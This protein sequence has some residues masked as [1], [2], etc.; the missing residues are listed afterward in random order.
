MVDG[1]VLTVGEPSLA[2]AIIAL[3]P[4]SSCTYSLGFFLGPGLPRGLGTPSAV[5][6]AA[7]AER[8][9]PFFLV[10]SGGAMEGAGVPSPAGVAALESDAGSVFGAAGEPFMSDESSGGAVL[11]DWLLT[12]PSASRRRSVEGETLSVTM[13]LEGGAIGRRDSKGPIAQSRVWEEEE[14]F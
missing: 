7:A 12:S 6:L 10:L 1:A 14:R 8:L 9:T 11:G 13:F 5:T 3:Q 2:H 4:K